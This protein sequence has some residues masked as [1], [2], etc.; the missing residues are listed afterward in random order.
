[1]RINGGMFFFLPNLFLPF[2][3]RVLSH[4]GGDFFFFALTRQR[5]LDYYDFI[6]DNRLL[7][8]NGILLIDNVLWKGKVVTGST[9]ASTS[10]E[11]EH[12]VRE[13]TEVPDKKTVSLIEFNERVR[14]D[15][16][17]EK[18]ML[19][20]R[21]GLFLVTWSEDAKRADVFE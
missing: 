13:A 15:E 11:G 8:K 19:P 5:Y 4:M 14:R 9:W 10:S 17:T 7:T 21:D 18:V 1:M 3:G 16:R 6:I 12:V 20:V 2:S